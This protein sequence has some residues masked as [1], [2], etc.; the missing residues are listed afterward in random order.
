MC[1]KQWIRFDLV[2][3]LDLFVSYSMRSY[4]IHML[5]QKGCEMVD[6]NN[7]LKMRE[8]MMLPKWPMDGSGNQIDLPGFQFET[9]WVFPSY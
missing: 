9:G 8:L 3:T 4:L 5:Y 6:S 2:R 1:D 7:W